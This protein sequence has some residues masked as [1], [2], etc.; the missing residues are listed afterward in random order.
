[1]GS[2]PAVQRPR[3]RFTDDLFNPDGL[4]Y[5]NVE[6]QI[7]AEKEAARQAAKARKLERAREV[8]ACNRL[9]RLAAAAAAD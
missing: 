8:Y 3:D 1:M 7:K 9:I 2:E 6:E 4:S 5:A